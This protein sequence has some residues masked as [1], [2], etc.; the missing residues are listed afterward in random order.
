M[1][2]EQQILWC[3]RGVVAENSACSVEQH[4]FAVAALAPGE[5][6]DMFLDVACERVAERPLHDGISSR[7]W[8]KMR[9]RKARHNGAA[10]PGGA[11]AT[12]VELRDAVSRA[13]LA[14]FPRAQV[15]GAGGRAEQIGSRSQS[16][17]PAANSRLLR[18]RLTTAATVSAERILVAARASSPVARS[19]VNARTKV[20]TRRLS[21]RSHGYR[22]TGT[23]A[24]HVST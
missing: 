2:D 16:A 12:A 14:Q 17:T 21:S 24:P 3:H 23:S 19:R 7:S 1:G 6:Q 15:Y 20:H 8:R 5:E 13:G 10:V 11:G 18:A 22:S 9:S 4:A